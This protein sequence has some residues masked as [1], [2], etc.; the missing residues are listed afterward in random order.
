MELLRSQFNITRLRYLLYLVT[1]EETSYEDPA[2]V[3]NYTQQ[4]VPW[5]TF[6]L[7][8]EY[9]IL[10]FQGKRN[11]ISVNDSITS[12]YGG[13]FSRFTEIRGKSYTLFLYLYVYENFR[14]VNLSPLSPYVWIFGFFAQDLCY[15]LG[16]R[17]VHEFGIFWSVHQM[18]HS[19]EYY[20]FATALRQGA[21]QEL[22]TAL[23]DINQALFIPPSTY[24]VHKTL[25]TLYQFW[26]HT[27]TIDNVGPVLEYI[28]NTPSHHRVHHGRNPYCIDK[29]YAGVLIIWDRLFGTFEAEK[30]DERPVYGL[31]TRPNTF[32][33]L[34]LQL[35][36]FWDIG[37][38]KGQM[39]D[40][41]GKQ[42]FPTIWDKIRVVFQSP[43]YFPGSKDKQFLFWRVLE[44]PSE[45]IPE[46]E[47]EVII[48]NPKIPQ[49]ILSYTSLHFALSLYMQSYMFTQIHVLS[50]FEYASYILFFLSQMQIAGYY[51]DVDGKAKG[52]DLCRQMIILAY[53][54]FFWKI[55]LGVGMVVSMMYLR[56][57]L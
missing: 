37:Y 9:I 35:F 46:I 54:I 57:L 6:L 7:F 31:V 36:E 1:P 26:I 29:N 24:V 4:V 47:K 51:F 19:S 44:N 5:F 15:Y 43:G 22:G 45:G 39:R 50:N 21:F 55:E 48:Y 14:L 34:Y 41:E 11:R 30:K 40:N 17:L 53:C 20:N 16:H 49:A 52:L 23:I 32:N 13:M 42:L 8:L 18:H 33:Q 2:D 10:T 3:P 28:F 25:N 56:F 12:M 27:E 38:N